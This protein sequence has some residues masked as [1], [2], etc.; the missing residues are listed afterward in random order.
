[1]LIGKRSNADDDEDPGQQT[2][3]LQPQR[4]RH[5]LSQRQQAEQH[6]CSMLTN[7]S[8]STRKNLAL[9]RC[10]VAS[11][12]SL[13]ILPKVSAAACATNKRISSRKEYLKAT[14]GHGGDS[15]TGADNDGVAVLE[16]QRL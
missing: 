10:I 13:D 3:R 1:M 16:A 8:E 12:H 5:R 14:C 6:A 11:C 15:G 2:Q 9:S 4:G 7:L